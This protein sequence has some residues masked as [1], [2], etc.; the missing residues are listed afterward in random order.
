M[1]RQTTT[2]SFSRVA[3]KAVILVVSTL[4]SLWLFNQGSTKIASR[5][6]QTETLTAASGRHVLSTGTTETSIDLN[7]S[8][9]NTTLISSSVATVPQCKPAAYHEFPPDFFTNQQRSNGA[10]IIHVLVT[11][12]MFYALAVVCD[13]YF[14]ASLQECSVRLN[15]SDDVAGA[16]FMAAGSSA[17]ELF[18]AILGV[19]IT[20]GDVGTATIVG[21]AVFNVLFVIGICGVFAGRVII[22]SW[23]PLFRDSSYYALT[24]VVLIIIIYDNTV[25]WYESLVM[26]IFYVIYIL[27]L[28]FNTELKQL[29]STKV[30]SL[31]EDETV[32]INIMS[33]TNNTKCYTSY[34]PFNDD[35][36]ECAQTT[37]KS[38][39]FLPIDESIRDCH[40]RISMYE[41]ALMI[42]MTRHFRPSTR[43]RCAFRRILLEQRRI[44]QEST[45]LVSQS[46]VDFTHF[47]RAQRSI[48]M[49]IGL[50]DE[51]SWKRLP[52]K[53]DGLF[54]TCQW[55]VQVPVL[56][57]LHYT[58]PDCKKPQWKR[59]FLLGFFI[60]VIWIAVF[61]YIMVWMVTLIGFTMGIPDSIMGITFLAAGTSVPDA[62]A[63]LLVA[64]QG[65]GDMAVSNSMGSN[66]FDILIGLA[67][68]WFIQTAMVE[69]GSLA[70]IDSKGLVYSVVLLFLTIIITI[71]GIYKSNWQLTRRLG[72][73]ALG[74]YFIFLFIS[75]MLEFNVVGRF[76]PLMCPE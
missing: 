13:D 32:A 45:K 28:K 74:V 14:I 62:F 18:T 50:M 52:R 41:A 71:Y 75:I 22:L 29:V 38:Q 58:I 17:P 35:I 53:E 36:D 10:I 11:I 61:S 16:T 66:V 48:S 9:T 30:S 68:P 24:V 2:T 7:Q 20:K 8:S 47:L 64:K 3:R 15:L 19:F 25:S 59:W 46:S 23:W 57:A 21:S 33:K 12:Y 54:F 44:K 42:M 60:S 27:L 72:M 40:R 69:P 6:A 73:L 51:T 37:V 43:F 55:L 56:A 34:V 5:M 31:Q 1:V 67:V 63:S 65:Q 39:P 4:I 49:S 70:K 76:N 26:L